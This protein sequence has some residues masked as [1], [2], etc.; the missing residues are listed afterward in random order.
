MTTPTA[1]RDMKIISTI[2]QMQSYSMETKRS[3]QR[4]ALV[5]TMGSLHEGHLSLIKRARELADIIV[6]SIFVNPTQF[7]P[8][9]DLIN[10]PRNFDYDCELCEKHGVDVIFAPPVS[11]MYAGNHSVWVSEEQLSQTLCGRSRPGHFRGVTT[12]VAKLFNITLPNY[13]IFGQKDAQQALIIKKITRDLNFPLEI[14]ISP[15]IREPN[16]LA[17]SSRNRYLSRDA[18]QAASVIYRELKAA[19]DRLKINGVN[20]IDSIVEGI[21]HAIRAEGG[22]IDYVKAL[23]ADNL[24]AISPSTQIILLAV[25]VKFEKARLIDNV[26]VYLPTT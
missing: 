8:D 5:P 14:I 7:A 1:V 11:E 19:K 9:E 10:Y 15:I 16:G 20:K 6:V 18:K 17:M 12:V 13:A 2:K 23:D 4:I 25:A 22:I 3:G 21:S 24:K 26:L